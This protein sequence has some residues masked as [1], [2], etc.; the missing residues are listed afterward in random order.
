MLIEAC[1]GV[2]CGCGALLLAASLQ[3]LL[4]YW[5]QEQERC[6]CCAPAL[7]ACLP[8]CLRLDGCCC[9][10]PPC[11]R[12]CLP[13]CLPAGMAAD[14]QRNRRESIC[15]HAAVCG[16][17]R[18]VHWHSAGN[19]SRPGRACLGREAG[20]PP[21]CCCAATACL[22]ARQAPLHVRPLM[23]A[24][25]SGLIQE[26]ALALALHAAGSLSC[27]SPARAV[28]CL[29]GCAQVGG[30]FEFMAEGFKDIFHKDLKI[31]GLPEV[32]CVPMQFLLDK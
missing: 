21:L 13:C 14:L 5:E 22:P 32:P 16:E 25:Q 17:F 4:R 27:T 11:R 7:A 28:G 19:V 10:L 3:P 1:P 6:G 18:T 26:A 31:D 9:F 2:A 20:L 8:L 15:L 23:P 30:I 12:S 29:P 24:V